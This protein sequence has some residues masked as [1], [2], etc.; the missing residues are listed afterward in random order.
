MGKNS[1]GYWLIAA[2]LLLVDAFS[3]RAFTLDDNSTNAAANMG[4]RLFL[5][6]RFAEFFFT[7]CGGDVNAI[8]PNITNSDY[9]GGEIIEHGETNIVLT[10]GDPVMAALH[11]I[12]GPQPGPFA[13]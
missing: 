12:Y 11:T 2:A 3:A 4:E 7:N 9:A 8:V 5:E 13:G 1:L 6:T 10:K